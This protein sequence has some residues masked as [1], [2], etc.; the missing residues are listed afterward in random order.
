MFQYA[1]R[2]VKE[3]KKRHENSNIFEIYGMQKGFTAT[4]G[5]KGKEKEEE[6]VDRRGKDCDML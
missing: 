1:M 4:A 5:A 2:N 6:T 3:G